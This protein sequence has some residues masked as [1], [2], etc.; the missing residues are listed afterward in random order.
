MLVIL[1]MSKGQ[2]LGKKS[3]DP[4]SRIKQHR[5]SIL[6]LL[7]SVAL[8]LVSQLPSAIF[9][10]LLI[11]TNYKVYSMRRG[12]QIM[13]PIFL[14]QIQQINYTFNFLVYATCG[15][16]FRLQFLEV[17]GKTRLMRYFV[18]RKTNKIQVAN[19]EEIGARNLTMPR[20]SSNGSI[21][22]YKSSQSCVLEM[23][24]THSN[25]NSSGGFADKAMT[26]E[27]Q[28]TTIVEETVTK[29]STTDQSEVWRR[30]AA[31]VG[32]AALLTKAGISAA[33]GVVSETK[34]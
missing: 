10:I 15:N 5:N 17:F 33:D 8:Y 6:V 1:A 34:I 23:E 19:L 14:S 13:G 25:G 21:S 20:N 4:K 24:L 2:S 28:D 7:G 3:G 9:A 11:A 30:V 22:S 27:A 16:H 31:E 32:S 29:N 12:S 26:S 18:H